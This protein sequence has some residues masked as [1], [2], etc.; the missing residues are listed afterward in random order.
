MLS[1]NSD[2]FT[3][4]SIWMTYFSCLIAL[5]R[6]LN[7][8]LNRSGK[9]GHPCIFPMFRKNTYI[10]YPYIIGYDVSCGLAIYKLYYVEVHSLYIHCIE[11]FYHKYMLNFVKC[12]F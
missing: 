7:T 6:T 5:D 3:S 8:M 4:F 1:A 2:S 11:S 12:F 9:D 10:P